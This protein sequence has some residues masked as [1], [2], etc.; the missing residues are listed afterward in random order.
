MSERS[1]GRE[2]SEQFGANERVSGTSERANGRASVPVLMC[3]FLVDPDHS[4]PVSCR[5]R[6][7][8]SKT[9]RQ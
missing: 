2:R 7:R 4:A 3:L 9:E 6:Q 1:R 5:E 8:D